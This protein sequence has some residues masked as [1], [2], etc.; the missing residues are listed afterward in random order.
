MREAYSV[1]SPSPMGADLVFSLITGVDVMG[2]KDCLSYF[3]DFG[4]IFVE[5]IND[6]S[7][8]VLFADPPSAKR[9]MVGRGRPL[10]PTENTATAG[11]RLL[12]FFVVE[13]FPLLNCPVPCLG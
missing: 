11:V 9:A 12:T 4:P 3:E 10:P 6:S 7:C 2:T 5:W 1:C 8:N 13:D